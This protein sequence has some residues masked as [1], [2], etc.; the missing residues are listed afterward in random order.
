MSRA[1]LQWQQ[2]PWLWPRQMQS[3]LLGCV[4]C[5]S[6]FASC[7]WLGEGE[8]A[9]RLQ[10]QQVQHAQHLETIQVLQNKLLTTRQVIERIAQTTEQKRGDTLPNVMQHLKTSATDIG[11]QLPVLAAPSVVDDPHL[12]F[13]L[14]GRYGAVW[15][16][17]QQ[18]QR[19]SS[20]LVLQQISLL[21][22]GD[23][24]QMTGKWLWSPL[25]LSTSDEKTQPQQ[26][27]PLPAN[28]PHRAASHHIGFDQ[29]AW[30]QAQRWHAQQLPSYAKWV[31]PELN[32]QP[33]HLEQFELRHLRY[34]GMIS[35]ANKQQALVR[36]LDGSTT[37]YPL[38]LLEPGVYLGQD[39]G[40]LQSITPEHLWLRE[41]VRGARGEWAPRWVKLPL[42]RLL[43]QA[44]SSKSAS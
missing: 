8:A 3:W 38:V 14:H 10:A 25:G 37:S 23:Q 26:S 34:E 35:S 33:H 24:L 30:L 27:L 20:A 2:A 28:Q 44:P 16:W 18:A 29:M 1:K 15:D 19:Q 5:L 22:D 7:L 43:E 17:W 9:E 32:R 40:R 4:C 12:S 11:L 42:G 13:E 21:P 41:V 31:M 36:I 39:F 6:F